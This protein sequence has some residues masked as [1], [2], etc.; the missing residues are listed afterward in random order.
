MDQITKETASL[1]ISNPQQTNSSQNVSESSTRIFVKPQNKT[2]KYTS[3]KNNTL[4]KPCR[5]YKLSGSC[6]FGDNCN[7]AHTLSNDNTDELVSNAKPAKTSSSFKDSKAS[8][9]KNACENT[10]IIIS[11][12]ASN[13]KL[14]SKVNQNK[15]PNNLSY[16][17][18]NETCGNI[19]KNTDNSTK[20]QSQLN[21]K[22]EIL[23]LSKSTPKLDKNPPK[24][25]KNLNKLKNNSLR[26]IEIEAVLSSDLWDST[27]LEDNSDETA[28]AVK[29]KPFSKDF[30]YDLDD[31]R[32]ALVVPKL[33]LSSVK[34]I[35]TPEIY[36]SNNNIPVGIKE[37]IQNAFQVQLEQTNILDKKP[38]LASILEWLGT[39]MEH[40][41]S[42]KP[43]ATVKFVSFT[44]NNN[45]QLN[46]SSPK[47]AEPNDRV[48]VTKPTP[49]PLLNIKSL[50]YEEK[51]NLIRNLH[52]NQLQRRFKESF[53]IKDSI[54]EEK[55]IINIRLSLTDPEIPIDVAYLFIE[56]SLSIGYAGT[57]TNQMTGNIKTNCLFPTFKINSNNILNSSNNPSNWNPDRGR[58]FYFSAIESLLSKQTILLKDYSL[59]KAVNWLDRYF[60]EII[61]SLNKPS[62]DATKKNNHDNTL[63]NF[64]QNLISNNSKHE[65]LQ[66]F[67]KT[68][69]NE[70]QSAKSQIPIDSTATVIFDNSNKKLDT[71]SSNLNEIE[72]NTSWPIRRGI[73]I[74][75]GACTFHNVLLVTCQKLNL[76]VKCG[77]CKAIAE[78]NNI[79]ATFQNTK[80]NNTWAA[81]KNCNSVMG[82]RFRANFVHPDALSLGFLDVS[83]CVPVDL[84][85]SKY[86]L[87]CANCSDN[88]DDSEYSDTQEENVN[89]YDSDNDNKSFNN[90]S[91]I[92]NL[93][94]VNDNKFQ[95]IELSEE[96]TSS[97]KEIIKNT[98]TTSPTAP[99]KQLQKK[100]STFKPIN[101]FTLIS[102]VESFF[103][104]MMCHSRLSISLNDSIFAKLTAGLKIG[105]SDSNSQIKNKLANLK[106]ENP[107]SFR[108]KKT[109]DTY[110]LILGSPLPHRGTCKHYPK[111]LRWF[112]FSCCMN[113]YPCD[114][115]HND[116]EDH[117][118]DIANLIVCGFCSKEQRVQ[119]AEMLGK[120]INCG[121]NIV[122]KKISTFWEGGKGT[123]NRKLMSRNDN[124][125]YK[126][127]NKT[128]SNK[129]VGVNNTNKK[130]KPEL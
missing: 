31:L 112:R 95:I 55:S 60:V 72:P 69:S 9:K 81:C 16:S 10:K 123:R 96:I 108:Q 126:G 115:C 38:R 34:K 30:P 102:N 104:C 20:M 83:N 73:E 99:V 120:C 26:M 66:S 84:K 49:K 117:G 7:F 109:K 1:Q 75:F 74:K 56:I 29:I 76:S 11:K 130:T 44:K 18:N 59:L 50:K 118:N 23:I 19:K 35:H 62:S 110:G 127:L 2:I 129:K 86:Q 57:I 93:S 37:N 42:M 21:K 67:N 52:I 43:S 41:F 124:R 89:D 33:Y 106:Q 111:S 12:T 97:T 65:K 51:T 36:I 128:V 22:T 13:I 103:N 17:K 94:I 79:L 6:R 32:L 113:L 27:T 107:S 114:I 48:P 14:N 87:L 92:K 82:V 47:N 54:F 119:K 88:S 80:D 98:S 105:D 121:E 63:R 61:N 53:N 15:L 71:F 28:I 101:C 4:T 8:I 122:K 90:E 24:S 85:P 5:F 91:V 3:S 64:S 45:L 46:A 70:N 78:L 77:K 68:S 100:I 125:K 25:K 58:D 116:K 39:N 40:L